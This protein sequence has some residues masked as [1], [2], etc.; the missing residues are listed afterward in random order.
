[1]T[2]SNTIEETDAGPDNIGLE[3]DDVSQ[4]LSTHDRQPETRIVANVSCNHTPLYIWLGIWPEYFL[5]KP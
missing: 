3:S 1:M 5:I 4:H 2:V